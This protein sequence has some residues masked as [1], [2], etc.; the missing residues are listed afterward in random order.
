[1]LSLDNPLLSLVVDND[2][3]PKDSLSYNTNF[4]LH[5]DPALIEKI[6][7]LS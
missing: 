2:S 3:T 6:L 4:S 5:V 1:M 7:D